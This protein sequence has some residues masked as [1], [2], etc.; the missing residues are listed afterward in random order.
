MYWTI[1][2]FN[3]Y[4]FTLNLFHYLKREWIIM[5]KIRK[6]TTIMN[7]LLLLITTFLVL[8]E[9]W[10]FVLLSKKDY[11]LLLLINESVT[12]ILFFSLYFLYFQLRFEHQ[13]KQHSYIKYYCV[14]LFLVFLLFYCSLIIPIAF[15]Q[16]TT[17]IT[18]AGLNWL[19][20][21]SYFIIYFNSFHHFFKISEEEKHEKEMQ[22]SLELDF[23]KSQ[24]NPHF[25]FN[26]LNNLF[27]MALKHENFVLADGIS[28]LANLIRY[29]IYEISLDRI[30][31]QK[32]IKYIESYVELQKLRIST[33]DN[34]DIKFTCFGNFQDVYLPPMLFI[35]F[36]ENAFKH[37]ISTNQYS[38]IEIRFEYTTHKI[39]SF[40]IKNTYHKNLQNFPK[41]ELNS[42]IGIKNTQ[43]RLELLLKNRYKL[44]IKQEDNYYQV[45]LDININTK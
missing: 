16:T 25:I 14:I 4:F 15:F 41:D 34:I 45:N 38:A 3:S 10:I 37:G 36:I 39:L 31:L 5:D 18:L 23:L 28:R 26:T 30:A 11:A 29:S 7:R 33:D 8:I 44:Q 43:K 42:G 2:P 21:L 27:S 22:L 13:I 9:Y 6:K 19:V 20:I 40:Y 35:N 24:I 1:L 12:K 17:F 32:E